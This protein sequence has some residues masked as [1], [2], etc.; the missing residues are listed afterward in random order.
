MAYSNH[1][2]VA[3]PYCGSLDTEVTDDGEISCHSCLRTTG[4]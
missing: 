3:C 1:D 2:A 4:E